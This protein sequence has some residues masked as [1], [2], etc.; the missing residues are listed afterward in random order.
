MAQSESPSITYLKRTTSWGTGGAGPEEL[1][2]DLQTWPLAKL[3][4]CQAC[5]LPDLLPTLLVP[6]GTSVGIRTVSDTG[7]L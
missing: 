1:G 5:S 2:S 4:I 3:A 6:A 7:C